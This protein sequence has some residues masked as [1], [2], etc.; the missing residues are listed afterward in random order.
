MEIRH[1]DPTRPPPGQ[2]ICLIFGANRHCHCP[3]WRRIDAPPGPPYKP[4]ATAN[5]DRAREADLPTQQAGAQAPSWLSPPPEDQGWP[6]SACRPASTRAQAA[7]RLRAAR[8]RVGHGTAPATRRLRS[9]RDRLKGPRQR[10]RASGA[11]SARGWTGAGGIY[12]FQEGRQL[13]RAQ[14]SAPAVARD[15]PVF[16]PGSNARGA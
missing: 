16:S 11:G 1:D 9:C 10:I 7:Q 12:R 15:G 6:Q 3:K 8:R 13:S 14:S 2:A 5:G 4:H